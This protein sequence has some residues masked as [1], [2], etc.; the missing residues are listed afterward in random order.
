MWGRVRKALIGLDPVRIEN[1]CELGTPD[2]NLSEGTWIELK[3]CRSAPKR[4]GVLK[5]DHYTTEQ[6]TWAIRR[7]HAGGRVFVLLKVSNEWL[8]F[9]G[10]TAPE[11]L[12]KV[13][14]NELREKAIKVWL[15]KLNDAELKELIIKS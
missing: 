13:S 3:W 4:G 10:H 14:L 12:G 1:R 15:Q 9:Y 11:F 5:I 6:H 8:L 7:H 2:V